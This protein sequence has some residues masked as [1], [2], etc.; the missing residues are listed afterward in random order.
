MLNWIV[1]VQLINVIL[2]GFRF[3]CNVWFLAW[4]VTSQPGELTAWKKLTCRL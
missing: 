2:L 1:F 4:L 3:K